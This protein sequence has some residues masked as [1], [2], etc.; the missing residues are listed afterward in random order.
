[1]WDLFWRNDTDGGRNPTNSPVEL[2]SFSHYLP[3]FGTNIQTV[4]G[5]G[6]SE[7]MFFKATGLLVL[8]LVTRMAHWKKWVIRLHQLKYDIRSFKERIST[9]PYKTKNWKCGYFFVFKNIKLD[10]CL[11]KSKKT[12]VM[13]I[14]KVKIIGIPSYKMNT[15]AAYHITKPP[16]LTRHNKIRWT[17]VQQFR[18][19]IVWPIN[20]PPYRNKSLMRPY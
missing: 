4:V 18:F 16:G 8:G 20:Q 14:V 1:M 15:Q 6:I 7:L 10:S 11:K 2:G 3:G 5:L 17:N 9:M 19:H 13:V 12:T